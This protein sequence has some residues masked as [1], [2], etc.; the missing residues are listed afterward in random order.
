MGGRRKER[1]EG[2]E[3]QRGRT[4]AAVSFARLVCCTEHCAQHNDLMDYPPQLMLF[5]KGITCWSGREGC[6]R[7]RLLKKTKIAT[8]SRTLMMLMCTDRFEC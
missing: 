2:L 7:R 6:V 8:V 1:R 4:A 5:R 3:S